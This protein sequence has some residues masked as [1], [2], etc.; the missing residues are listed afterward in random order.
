MAQVA[1]TGSGTGFAVAPAFGPIAASIGAAGLTNGLNGNFT[2]GRD[3]GAN[4]TTAGEVCFVGDYAGTSITSG[5]F[6]TAFGH[7]ALGFET[8]GGG[9]NAF[10]NDALRTA[11]GVANSVAIANSGVADRSD[12]WDRPAP[13][14][15]HPVRKDQRETSARP[16]RPAP[17]THCPRPA[18]RSWAASRWMAAAVLI[19]S[20][21]ISAAKTG[22]TTNDNANAG[23]VGEYVSI[24]RRR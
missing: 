16:G 13:S 10:G 19:S 24:N 1:T 15:A 7:R 2:L 20:G 23:A 8:M 4:I 3:A 18:R 5:G 17:P 12:P 21:T 22:T 9:N 11:R 14:Q 6:N